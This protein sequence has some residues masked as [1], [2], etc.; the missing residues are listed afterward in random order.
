MRT[1]SRDRL[2][3]VGAEIIPS[4]PTTRA[5]QSAALLSRALDVPISVEF[6]LHEW[7]PDLTWRYDQE[8]V[9]DAAYRE[10][11]D[12]S[13][14]WPAGETRNWE[15]LSKVRERVTAVLGRYTHLRRLIVVMG[16]VAIYSLTGQD[17]RTGTFTEYTL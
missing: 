12:L 16:N 17:L 13:G 6:D 4:S 8:A 3:A 9:A 7:I 2:R 5:L 1:L 14:E 10:M 15:P 11:M